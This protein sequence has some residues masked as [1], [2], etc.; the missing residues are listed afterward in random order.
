MCKD[1]LELLPV[2]VSVG[3]DGG[4]TIDPES[5]YILA[6]KKAEWAE[7]QLRGAL[8]ELTKSPDD[9]EPFK[10]FL[11][12]MKYLSPPDG[13]RLLDVGCGVGHYSALINKYFSGIEY[14]G[15]DFSE[16]MIEKAKENFGHHEFF[17]A[18]YKDVDY[19]GYGVVLVSGLIT[20][21][22]EF[23]EIIDLISKQSTGIVIWH[24]VFITDDDSCL[25]RPA[26]SSIYGN[27]KGYHFYFNS[28]NLIRYFMNYFPSV[29]L[30]VW[31]EERESFE[32]G[33]FVCEYTLD[34]STRQ[35]LRTETRN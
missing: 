13:T 4:L 10:Y 28:R 21:S 6:W 25:V 1:E 20:I 16:A 23:K 31:E 5:E 32:I 35:L 19:S 8:N 17:V 3:Q 27:G 9:V 7:E 12:V 30:W 24:R 29:K 14:T 18:D 33:T 26:I 2:L 11:E 34:E 15:F 22:P